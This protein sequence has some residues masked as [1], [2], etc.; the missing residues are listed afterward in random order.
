VPDI[1]ATR[2]STSL[3]RLVEMNS[4]NLVWLMAPCVVDLECQSSP[5]Y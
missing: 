2:H 5:P 1:S 4:S 3:I